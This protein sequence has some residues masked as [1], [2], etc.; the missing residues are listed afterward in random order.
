[1]PKNTQRTGALKRTYL[2]MMGVLLVLVMMGV[3]L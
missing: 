2:L 3:V 1:M